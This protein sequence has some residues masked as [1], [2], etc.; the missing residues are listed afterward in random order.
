MRFAVVTYRD[1]PPQDSTYVTKV[2]DF[3]DDTEII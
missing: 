2:K 1:H 3:T